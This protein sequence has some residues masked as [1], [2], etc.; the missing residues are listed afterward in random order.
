VTIRTQVLRLLATRGIIDATQDLTLRASDQSERDPVLAQLVT[1]EVSGTALAGP[2][3][4][5][6]DGGDHEE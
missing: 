1:A 4:R 2:E 6:G 3:R 5:P